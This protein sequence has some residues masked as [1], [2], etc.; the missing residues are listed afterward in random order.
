MRIFIGAAL[1]WALSGC[2]VY[3]AT[4]Q[5]DAKN[6]D[7]FTVGTP[8]TL[9]L[10]E[11]GMPAATETKNGRTYEIFKFVNGYTA[12]AKAGRAVF[13]GAADVVT[14]GLWEVVGTPTEGVFF[15]GDEMVFRVRYDK[16]DRIDE[17]V[18]LKR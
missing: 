11:F 16:D 9:M 10:A 18:A 7:L 17:V 2:S 8:R 6:V 14:L 4:K 12:G 13:H 5:P 1:C 15:T 3:M